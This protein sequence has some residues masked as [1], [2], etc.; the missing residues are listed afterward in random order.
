MNST[1]WTGSRRTRLAFWG[2]VGLFLVYAGLF[3]YRTSF[4]VGNDRYFSY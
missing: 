4:I 1:H 2:M 3:I